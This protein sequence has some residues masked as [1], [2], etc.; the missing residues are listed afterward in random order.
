M[1]ELKVP[2]EYTPYKEVWISS[3]I[4]NNG[5]VL[6]EI[7]GT[8]VFLLG[9]GESESDSRI[10]LNAPKFS[11]GKPSWEAVIRNSE[12]LDK[13]YSINTT[14]KGTEVTFK[15]MPLIQFHV[16]GTKLIITLVNFAP[17][18]LNIFGGY[19]SIFVNGNELS[20][21]TFD[22]VGTMVGVGQ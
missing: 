16:D 15:G 22:H 13:N 14:D 10:W 18:N 12:I 5:N 4:F 2:S 17:I 6:F 7:D 20:N 3:N 8:P 1:N 9:I 21:N 19:K 11:G